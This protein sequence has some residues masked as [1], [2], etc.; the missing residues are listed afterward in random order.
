ME[1]IALDVDGE[2]CTLLAIGHV[3]K[4]AFRD[5]CTQWL[6]DCMLW[7]GGS[8]KLM[9]GGTECYLAAPEPEHIEHTTGIKVPICVADM[10]RRCEPECKC[11][12]VWIIP[13]D[14]REAIPLTV[15]ELWKAEIRH[16]SAM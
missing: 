16:S 12:P 13:D 5:A 6:T 15:W 7:E 3:D 9:D 1:L 2:V 11:E 14:R 4:A 10:G 8:P